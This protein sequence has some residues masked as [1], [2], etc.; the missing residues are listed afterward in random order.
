MTEP[1]RNIG[2]S[3]TT[4]FGHDEEDFLTKNAAQYHVL[5]SREF[6]ALSE[7]WLDTIWQQHLLYWP[8]E[9]RTDN[10]LKQHRKR[11]QYALRWL[12]NALDPDA[13]KRQLEY[14]TTHEPKVHPPGPHEIRH[15]TVQPS[16]IRRIDIFDPPTPEQIAKSRAVEAAKYAVRTPGS[17]PAHSDASQGPLARPPQHL[18]LLHLAL[19]AVLRN[20]KPKVKRRHIPPAHRHH[21][22][23]SWSFAGP[24]TGSLSVKHGFIRL[25]VSPRKRKTTATGNFQ[26]LPDFIPGSDDIE[27]QD[28]FTPHEEYHLDPDAYALAIAGDVDDI[29]TAP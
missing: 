7:I 11:I 3:A 8:P 6:S 23:H 25:P 5:E 13:R 15:S 4:G 10:G 12:F 21:H 18:L 1:T 17:Q 9:D 26:D 28:S 20:P 16:R 14:A 29:A 19:M 2:F 27:D 22:H 24:S